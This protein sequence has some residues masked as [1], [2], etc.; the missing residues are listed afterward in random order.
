M[1]LEEPCSWSGEGVGSAADVEGNQS[2]KTYRGA[3]YG[4]THG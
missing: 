2:L 3:Y 1:P 4:H